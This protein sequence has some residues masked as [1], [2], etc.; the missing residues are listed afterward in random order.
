M[1]TLKGDAAVTIREQVLTVDRE[2]PTRPELTDGAAFYQGDGD[3]A[4]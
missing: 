3:D 1:T 4:A 2:R